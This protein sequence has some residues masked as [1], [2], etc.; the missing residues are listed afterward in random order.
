MDLELKE[1]AMKKNQAFR[2]ALRLQQGKAQ[3]AG[4]TVH[5]HVHHHVH[6][7]LCE[8][9]PKARA[10]RVDQVARIY[11]VGSDIIDNHKE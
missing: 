11:I 10:R 8:P 9:A 4:P 5:V 3:E 2:K 1:E 7:H 6:I